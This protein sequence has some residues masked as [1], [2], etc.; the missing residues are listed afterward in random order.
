MVVQPRGVHG[1]P[2]DGTRVLDVHHMDH[3]STRDARGRAGLSVL[4]R[5]DYDRLRA[6][7]GSHL[8]DGCAGEVLLIDGV[9]PLDGEDLYVETT[10][11]GAVRLTDVRVAK[12]CLQFTRFCLRLPP[13]A[14]VD[15]RV[16]DAMRFLDGGA[17]GFRARGTGDPA[18]V[19]VGARMWAGAP[20]PPPRTPID[21]VAPAGRPGRAVGRR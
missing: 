18:E 3:P 14:P 15:A 4:T 1:L 19:A 17:R 9:R 12:P 13:E 7:F 5:S 21:A 11:G 16:Q 20:T 10:A 8:V 6:R 2:G